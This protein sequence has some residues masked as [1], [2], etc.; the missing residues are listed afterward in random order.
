MHILTHIRNPQH[1]VDI[2][3]Q[4]IL[5]AKNATTETQKVTDK[6]TDK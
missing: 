6:V 2:V 1:C 5:V 4:I 3:D